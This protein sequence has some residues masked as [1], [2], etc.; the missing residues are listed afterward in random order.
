MATYQVAFTNLTNAQPMSP[1]A[2][3]LHDGSVA[4][5]QIGMPASAGIEVLAESGDG[6]TWLAEATAAGAMV[7]ANGEGI[8]MPGNE[9]LVTLT[10][11]TQQSV[12]LGLATMLVNTND[13]FTGAGAV[14]LNLAVGE[15]ISGV[16]PVMDAGTEANSELATT[17]PGPAGGGTGYDAVRDDVGD[18]VARHGGIVGIDDGKM[19]SALGHQHRFDSP[20]ANWR[21]TRIE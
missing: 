7:T 9:Q 8:V 10:V 13:A 14:Y 21:V 12:Y 15:A 3:Y 18:Y 17:I 19:D 5:W 11:A 1:L 6:S 16:V 2:A 20:V 4:S